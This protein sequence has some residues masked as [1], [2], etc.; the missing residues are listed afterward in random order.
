MTTI[1]DVAVI[2]GGVTGCSTALH[3]ARGGMQTVIVERR[4]LCMEA[5][6]VNAG[7]LCLQIKP[8]ALMPYAL[9]AMEMWRTAGNWLGSEVGFQAKGS[10]ML[11]FSED[12][13][14]LLE[15]RIGE[16][17]A[18]GAP[19]DVIDADAARRLEP[20]LSPR[21]VLASH[22]QIDGF[23][24]PTVIGRAYGAALAQAGVEFRLG[25]AV[26]A[27]DRDGGAFTVVRGEDRLRARRIVL[28]GG[29][30]LG[31]MA[32]W[33]G[34]NLPVLCRPYQLAV[35]ERAP[36][37]FDMF[38]GLASARLS[39]KQL[40]GGGVLV[41]GG[42]EGIGDIERGGLG[43]VSERLVG[44]LRLAH[45]A[46]PAMAGLRLVRTWIGLEVEFADALPVVGALPGVEDVFING[47]TRSGFTMAPCM[48]KLLAERMLGRQPDLPLFDPGRLLRS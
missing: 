43:V 30:W 17:R 24:D 4:G 40:A 37:L 5:S 39:L 3:L 15:T 6:G 16:R 20:A 11:A 45:C 35:S 36:R 28:A 26:D 48:G 7:S 18:A 46:V 22:C 1:F 32:R 31:E 25:S 27:V 34:L 12:D 47:G 38:I 8:L 44:N 42:W 14:G 41:G 21:P 29:V 13:A 10:L 2:G 19:I 33:F 9:N 23:A